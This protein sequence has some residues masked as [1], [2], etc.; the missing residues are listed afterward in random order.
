M[1]SFIQ[2]EVNESKQRPKVF[3]QST[4]YPLIISYTKPPPHT[5]LFLLSHARAERERERKLVTEYCL[6]YTNAWN[7]LCRDSRLCQVSY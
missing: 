5:S 4:N 7:S 6:C 2:Q 1:K 3:D